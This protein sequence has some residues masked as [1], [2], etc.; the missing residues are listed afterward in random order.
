MR[1]GQRTERA[2]RSSPCRGRSGT[3]QGFLAHPLSST[4]L[5]TCLSLIHSP[6]HLPVC[7]VW[8]VPQHCMRNV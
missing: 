6:R 2:T 3:E 4:L 1:V 8:E 5:A 7:I